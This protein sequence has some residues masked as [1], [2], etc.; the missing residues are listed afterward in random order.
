MSYLYSSKPYYY[1]QFCNVL[2]AKITTKTN[3]H[4]VIAAKFP[5]QIKL[6]TV[7]ALYLLFRKIFVL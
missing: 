5:T 7:I 3:M 2:E 4:T 1:N 6:C